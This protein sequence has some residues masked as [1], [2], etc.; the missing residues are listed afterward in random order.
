M[1]S[2]NPRSETKTPAQYSFGI[3]PDT[4]GGRFYAEW[5]DQAPV[6]REGQL[7][8]FLQFLVTMLDEYAN[9]REF[10][11]GNNKG[12]EE[13]FYLNRPRTSG[14][15]HGQSPMLWTASAPAPLTRVV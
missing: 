3:W 11:V 14:D 6:T 10:C 5:D 13:P 12:F 8:F 9:L 1:I 15:L 7:I 2:A 4:P